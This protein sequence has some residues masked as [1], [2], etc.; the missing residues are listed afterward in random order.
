[1]K[2]ILCLTLVLSAVA[3][4]ARAD[5]WIDVTSVYIANPNYD[6]N[7]NQGWTI[8][9]SAGS[10]SCDWGAQ[11]FWNGT[12]D[13]SQTAR[14]TQ[15]HY[16]LTVNGYH[17]PGYFSDSDADN[18]EAVEITSVLYANGTSVPLRSVYS[19]SLGTNY[20]W[21]CWG[22]WDEASRDM[23]YYP[24]NMEAGAYCFDRGM[25]V[26]ELEFDITGG[27]LVFGIRNETYEE[28][29]W[30]IFDNWKLEYYG[31]VSMVSDI[32]LSAAAMGLTVG[33]K[34]QL[35][36]TVLPEDATIKLLSWTSGNEAVATVDSEGNVTGVATG[37]ATITAAATDGSGVKATC[38][39]TVGA[40]TEGLADI[41]I[42]EIQSANVD[43]F[44]DPSWNYG[45]WVELYNPAA[46]AVSLTGC[47]VSDDPQN[48]Q[49]VYIGEPMAIPAGGYLNLWFDH[50]DKY[51]PTQLDMK[52][53]AEGG[54]IYISD[55]RGKLIASQEYP[56]AVSRCSYARKSLTGEAWAWTSTPTPEQANDGSTY[57][58]ERLAAPYVDQ[59]SQIYGTVL[60]VCVNIPEGATLRYTTD[61]SA[62]TAT[63]GAT[64]ATGLFQLSSATTVYRF[65]LVGDGYLPSPVVTRTYIYK[66]KD[67]ALPVFSVASANDNLYGADYGIF[68]QGNGNGRPGN[69]Q[70]SACNWNMD[71]DRPANFEYI[72]QEGVMEVNQETAME[73]CGGWSRA[74]TPYSFKVKANKQYELQSYLPC[75]FFAEKPYLKHK[76]LQMRNGGNDTSCRIKDPALQEIVLRSGIDVNCQAYLPVMHYINGKYAGVIN[77]REPN[78]KHYVY[79]NYGLDDDEID[80]FEMSPDSGY[81][82]K[83]GTYESMQRWYD[84]SARCADDE[85]YE[86]I[87]Q[88]VD[89]DEYCNYMA[90]EF[91]LG[92]TDWPQNNVKGWKPITEGGKYRFILYDLDFAFNST[93]TFSD[94]AGKQ[95]YTFDQLYGEPVDH[96]TK[97]IEMVTIFLN[98]LGNDQFRRQFI[99]SYCLVAG[100][101]FE[102]SRCEAI[103]NELC[104]NVSAS[105]SI[106]SEV[107]GSGSTPWSTAND[108]LG[109]L[110][111]SRRNTMMNTLRNY[112]AMKLSG[113]TAQNVKLSANIS[114]AR[115]LV[116]DLPVPTN[117]F[118][119]Q[120]FAPVTLRAQ[121]PAGYKFDGW[122]LVS[123]TVGNEDTLV[124]KGG[125]WSY[126]DQG[127][128]D[129]EDWTAAT[130]DYGKWGSGKAPIGYCSG[131]TMTTN[132][133]K[134]LPTYYFRTALTLDGTPGDGDTFTLD[135]T[136]DD[137]FIIYVNGTEA[138][139]YNMPSGTV[140]YSDLATTYANGNPD[141][142]TMSL[143]A[144]LFKKGENHIAVEVHNNDLTS[145]DIYWDAS[146]SHFASETT[147]SYVSADEEYQMPTSGDM[148]LQACYSEMSDE[149]KSG[150]GL[151][152]APVVINEVSAGNSVNVNEYYKKDD[153]VELYNTT[154]ED[155]DLEGMY[156]TD[157][158]NK[159]QK[160][161]ITAA[162]TKASTTIP[163]HGYK[164]IW[165]SGR[166]TDTEL[167]AS[168]KLGN[169]DGEMVRIAA[170]DGS[171]ADS[172]VY[173]AHNGDQSVGR[174]PDGGASVYLMTTPTIKAAN[175][176]TT[177][178]SL[179]EYEGPDGQDGD[180]EEDIPNHVLASRSGGMSIACVGDCLSIK[181]EDS[182]RVTFGVYTVSG[183]TVMYGTLG[184]EAGHGRVSVSALP[185]GVY[186]ARATD[187]DGGECA[188]KFV[189]R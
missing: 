42:T 92:S 22:H 94:F 19:E 91:F 60:T 32:V 69:G 127:S 163:A 98:M 101:V 58:E 107:Y 140:R 9:A 50:H 131:D 87:K 118:D 159:P 146:V 136:V 116:N 71:W 103:I 3:M 76:S 179:W 34:A 33:E 41:I 185:A 157:N 8:S 123:G 14:L 23:V 114:E 62:P 44:I 85:V 45:G 105:Q 124:Q 128:L 166:D 51:C 97:E 115:L 18:Y 126:Y 170:R 36:A 81:V 37:V 132:I 119:G 77:M 109:S 64:S 6:G 31:E 17:R 148:T 7:S 54:A 79:A 1:M 165:C 149:E 10:T 100:S 138:G 15:G 161:Q 121:A 40:S 83:C 139:R 43:Q 11:E 175:T 38:T 65:C 95:T 61:G 144:S 155:I 187:G 39:V 110:T 66:D 24:N 184:M 84:L 156:M 63:N 47:W 162:G 35:T 28:G 67:F 68:V 134:S 75:D 174:Y 13:I 72:N 152:T 137:G 86:E 48:L 30:S 53:D 55:Y 4:A 129:D 59:D 27:S 49:K 108:M 5:S 112:S 104:D 20:N 178:A 160:Y 168:F 70:S 172:L 78:N 46:S 177:Y 102:P 2:K 189:K 25:Y 82:Q 88:M 145:S 133:A 16:R 96:I 57:C 120:L 164:V 169:N 26:N 141:K 188:T 142:G 111:A 52:L 158:S 143:S 80:Q 153:W 12:W 21:G 147:G 151:T 73:R 171:W 74:W 186:I 99:D 181:S 150:E 182:D 113:T 93:N 125:V 154:A 117:A 167:H 135:Y 180:G 173:C 122:K 29:N 56:E 183:V 89:I 130:Y 176:M 106:R 90:V